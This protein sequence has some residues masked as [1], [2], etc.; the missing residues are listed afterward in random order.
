MS[1]RRSIIEITTAYKVEAKTTEI[2]R[3]FIKS[4]I[5]VFA[6]VLLNP[7]FSSRVNVEYTAR[8]I[9]TISSI[10]T[11]NNPS[12]IIPKTF[13]CVI[14]CTIFVKELSNP[15]EVNNKRTPTEIVAVNMENRILSVL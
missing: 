5:K 15:P 14:S 11:I 2:I 10:R 7:Y 13:D 6:V 3:F 8:G 12:K 1:P 4:C 9:P